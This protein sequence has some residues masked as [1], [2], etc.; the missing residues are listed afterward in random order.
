MKTLWHLTQLVLVVNKGGRDQA[1]AIKGK[2][3]I[4]ES[5]FRLRAEVIEEGI[6]AD[7]LKYYSGFVA[8]LL[9]LWFCVVA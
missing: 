6:A 7:L 1:E 9:S 4:L 3:C 2:V 5:V 8:G